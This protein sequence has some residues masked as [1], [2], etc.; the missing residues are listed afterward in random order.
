[1]RHVDRC[2]AVCQSEPRRRRRRPATVSRKRSSTR[3]TQ[4][5]GLKVIARTSAFAFKGKNEDIRRIANILGVTLILEGSVRRAGGRV[6]VTAQ[7]VHAADG[8][9]RWSQRYDREMS[10]ILRCPGRHRRGDC[11]SAEIAAW[12]GTRAPNA[13][14]RRHTRRISDT[15]RTSGNSLPRLPGAAASVW[16]RRSRSIPNSHCRM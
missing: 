16:S 2:A 3:L 8:A 5:P 14:P 13:K 9:H 7:L 4:V 12:S 1:M 10:D 11:G 6:R 15:G